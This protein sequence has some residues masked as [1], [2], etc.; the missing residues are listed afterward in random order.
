MID[1][2]EKYN[3]YLLDLPQLIKNAHFKSE[4]FIKQLNVSEA[5]YY[6]K[7]REHSFSPTEVTLLTELL[8]PDEIILRYLEKSEND[9]KEGKVVSHNEVKN[10][11]MAKYFS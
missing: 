9:I 8:F 4:Y 2:V 1:I 7:L 6:R 5:T 3:S 11:L 10:K